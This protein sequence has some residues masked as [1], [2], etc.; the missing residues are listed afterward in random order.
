SLGFADP[1]A[2]ENSLV[3][4]RAPVAEFARFLDR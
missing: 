1:N 2:V 4:E 3:T